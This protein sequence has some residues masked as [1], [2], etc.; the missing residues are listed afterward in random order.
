MMA[1]ELGL[2]L[3]L[4]LNAPIALEQAGYPVE[5]FSR[6]SPVKPSD[7]CSPRRRRS[8]CF[9]ALVRVRHRRR[10][11]LHESTWWRTASRSGSFILV[12]QLPATAPAWAAD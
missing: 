11:D 3:I 9:I 12:R 7:G 6:S 4:E 10:A 1:K 8:C 2:P 5:R